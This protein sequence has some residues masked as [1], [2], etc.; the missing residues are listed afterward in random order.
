MRGNNIQTMLFKRN[1]ME[2]TKILVVDD[3]QMNLDVI[4]T[5]LQI[6]NMD[7]REERVT[8]CRDGEKALAIIQESV[9]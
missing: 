9:L 4:A 1:Q 2:K 3:E 5:Y 6:L 8:Y 7:G